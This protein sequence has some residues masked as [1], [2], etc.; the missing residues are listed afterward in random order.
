MK[1]NVTFDALWREVRKITDTKIEININAFNRK[2]AP[3]SST[4]GVEIDITK[5][6][7]TPVATIEGRHV[8]L[9]I[10]DHSYNFDEVIVNPKA[11]GN[12]Y[13][14]T[15]CKALEEMRF[16]GRFKR[17][18]ATNNLSGKFTIFNSDNR[19]AE[20]PLSVCKYCL[21]KLNYKN[22]N[23]NR[24]QVFDEFDLTEFFNFY[25]TQ[26]RN[27]PTSLN[28]PIGGYSANWRTISS[29]YRQS[30]QWRCEDCGLNL[31]DYPHL[32]EVHHRNGVKSD[33]DPR[34]LKA[35]CRECHAKQEFHA[36]MQLS[37]EDRKLLADLRFIQQPP[38]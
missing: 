2:L 9:F 11:K 22:Y 33:N 8:L 29:Q 23:Q 38:F 13:H 19:S 17:Y 18:F 21:G 3:I 12:K 6:N 1:L 20:V 4:K 16:K 36:H 15:D 24:Q 28:E 10:P 5:V 26:F 25:D 37:E 31:T 14:L 32:L 7:F 27:L 30:R 35:V 34:N